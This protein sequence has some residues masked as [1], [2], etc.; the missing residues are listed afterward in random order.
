MVVDDQTTG[1]KILEQLI[2]GI[3]PSLEVVAFDDG[4]SAIDFIR[5][6]TPDLILTDY[7][8]PGMDGV[9]FIR[10][11][12]AL[13]G[14]GDLPIIVVT[15]VEDRRVLYEALDA[16][17]TDFLN[18]PIDQH[19][20]RARCRNLLTMRR[21]QQIIRNRARWLEAQ[22]ELAT[23]E[24][25]AREEETLLRLAKAGEYRDECTGN[26]VLRIAEYCGLIATGL[27]LAEPACKAI[28]LAA[29]MHDI[30][31]IGIPDAILLKPGKLTDA[32]FDIMRE[33][34]RLG[35]QILRDSP[36]TYLQLGATIALSHHEKF[37]GSGYPEGLRGEAIPQAARIVAV[38]DVFDALTTVRPYK[39]A[40]S[41]RDAC[42]YIQSLSGAHFDPDCVSAFLSSVPAIEDIRR[43]LRDG[44]D[45][46]AA[47]GLG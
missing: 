27:G 23:K 44:P 13:P 21:Q 8:M 32:E 14:C 1:R 42:S 20:C 5:T 31:K 16:G 3:D 26:H 30:G 24:I 34:A 43:Q 2:R 12:R 38:A 6:Q 10:Q 17:A 46:A 9:S 15:V 19:E 4:Q 25:V 18:R 37:D 33:H 35:Y 47:Q 36:S 40:W 28:S 41:S 11:V 29:T 45:E 7:L 22:V 39:A